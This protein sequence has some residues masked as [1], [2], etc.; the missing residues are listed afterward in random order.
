MMGRVI[1]LAERKTVMADEEEKK[2]PETT[3]STNT[4]YS[5]RSEDE[6]NQVVDTERDKL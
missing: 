4:E 2:Q 1:F 5:S 6:E 3:V